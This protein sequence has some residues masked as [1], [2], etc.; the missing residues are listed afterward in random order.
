MM[1]TLSMH[2]GYALLFCPISR[3]FILK[4]LPKSAVLRPIECTNLRKG[5]SREEPLD[6]MSVYAQNVPVTQQ[7]HADTAYA[8]F[9]QRNN[10]H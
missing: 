7:M 9:V 6:P 1:L 4:A 3:G 10:D 8:R 5:E 2:A